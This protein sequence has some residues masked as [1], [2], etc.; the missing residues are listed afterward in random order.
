MN[1]IG[2]KIVLSHV[3]RYRCFRSVRYKSEKRDEALSATFSDDRI[4]KDLTSNPDKIMA[5]EKFKDE[6][7]KPMEDWKDKGIQMDEMYEKFVEL[8]D[9]DS[10][11]R[12]QARDQK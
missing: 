3:S 2:R 4:S 10:Q 12:V 5:P 6:L 7:D 11:G 8:K 1:G 9:Y